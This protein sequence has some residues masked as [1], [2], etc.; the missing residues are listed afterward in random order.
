[1]ISDQNKGVGGGAATFDHLDR[2]S[3]LEAL[4]VSQ[5]CEAVQCVATQLEGETCAMASELM[6]HQYPL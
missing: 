5:L 3:I 4:S 6:F 2:C 1:M